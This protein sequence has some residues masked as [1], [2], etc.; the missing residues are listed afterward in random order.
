MIFLSSTQWQHK[1]TAYL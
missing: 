1:T